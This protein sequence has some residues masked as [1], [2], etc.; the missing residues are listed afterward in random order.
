MGELAWWFMGRR[1]RKKIGR[2]MKAG[3]LGDG[4][5]IAFKLF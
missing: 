4:E 2:R 5:E 3:E 1:T